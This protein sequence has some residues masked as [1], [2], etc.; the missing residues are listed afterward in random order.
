V[1]QLFSKAKSLVRERGY[2]SLIGYVMKFL[3][4]KI[5]GRFL[6]MGAIR[7]IRNLAAKVD[8]IESI[9]RVASEFRFVGISIAPSQIECEITELLLL[10]KRIGPRAILEIGTGSG[11]T[12]FLFTRMASADAKVISVDLPKGKFG[13]GYPVWKS[14]LF[15]SFARDDQAVCLIRADSHKPE[16][17]LE[18]RKILDNRPVDFLFI[19]GDH[20]YEGVRKDF[21]MYSP[22]VRNGGII[23]FH[24]ICPRPK[25]NAVG[26]PD[27]WK[28]ISVK[29]Q[30]RNILKDS[31]QGGCGIGVLLL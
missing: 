31:A 26:V 10:I 19:D 14:G 4:W 27:F 30:S 25:E 13:G 17:L 6:V 7:K 8:S 1:H 23:A 18:V 5:F 24:D 29:Y 11:G 22:L 9:M 28:E 20:T 21:E 16:T 15:K 3:L 2:V 12:L